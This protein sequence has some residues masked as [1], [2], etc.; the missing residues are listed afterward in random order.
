MI[1]DYVIEEKI[2][3]KWEFAMRV[4][5]ENKDDAARIWLEGRPQHPFRVK[6][7]VFAFKMRREIL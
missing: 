1:R 3:G 5:A 6:L 2:G 4:S 7:D